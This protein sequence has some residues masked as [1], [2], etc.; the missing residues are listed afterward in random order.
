[1]KSILVNNCSKS[2]FYDG[3][4]NRR[5]D[6]FLTI[7]NERHH[8]MYCGAHSQ[9]NKTQ[10]SQEKG[11]INTLTHTYIQNQKLAVSNNKSRRRKNTFSTCISVCKWNM[12]WNNSAK[13]FDRNSVD[14]FVFVMMISHTL[15]VS[16]QQHNTKATTTTNNNHHHINTTKRTINLSPKH[17]N[18]INGTFFWLWS[19]GMDTCMCE[20]LACSLLNTSQLLY[21]DSI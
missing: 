14:F 16:S 5:S 12:E 13:K 1:M 9:S 10:W 19:P 4:W 8:R 20:S 17:S 21:Y 6:D 2:Y 11:N 3:N 18:D 15:F 7:S